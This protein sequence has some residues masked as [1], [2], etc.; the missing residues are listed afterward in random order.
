MGDATQAVL[1]A[2]LALAERVIA[3]H[4]DIAATAAHAEETAFTFARVAGAPV[5]ADLPAVLSA[6][7]IAADEERMAGL[8]THVAKIARRVR[9]GV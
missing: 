4:V 5:A 6:I 1:Q 3:S 9:R 8:A 7:Q 2:D